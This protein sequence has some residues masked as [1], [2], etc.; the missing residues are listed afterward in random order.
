MGFGAGRVL[1][2]ACPDPAAGA[3]LPA[4]HPLPQPPRAGR[5][6][7]LSL[8]TWSPKRLPPAPAAAPAP[9]PRHAAGA[10]APRCAGTPARHASRG[11]CREMCDISTNV[12]SG[13]YR[14]AEIFLAKHLC[15]CVYIFKHIYRSSN[16]YTYVFIKTIFC[17]LESKRARKHKSTNKTAWTRSVCAR[18]CVLLC[19]TY[20]DIYPKA[21]RQSTS[22]FTYRFP[23][24]RHL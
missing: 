5:V 11:A 24:M 20:T 1:L 12:C 4:Q 9:A 13:I 16:V 21:Q 19:Y 2:A 8:H 7:A 18:L 23:F 10:P 22:E 6:P 17:E 3:L 14:Y 15:V